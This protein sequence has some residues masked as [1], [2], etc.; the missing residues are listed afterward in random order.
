MLFDSSYLV[1][2]IHGYGFASS[3]KGTLDACLVFEISLAMRIRWERTL[4]ALMASIARAMSSKAGMTICLKAGR[5]DRE[6]ARQRGN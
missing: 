2:F 1:V 5:R 6:K 3:P 4:M